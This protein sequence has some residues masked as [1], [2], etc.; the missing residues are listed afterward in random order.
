MSP[1]E[2]LVTLQLFKKALKD[3]NDDFRLSALIMI[4]E[5]THSSPWRK[6]GN[7]KSLITVC[8]HTIQCFWSFVIG[9]CLSA[10]FADLWTKPTKITNQWLWWLFWKDSPG[11]GKSW[12]WKL[13]QN[14]WRRRRKETLPEAQRTQGIEFK[15]WINFFIW[16]TFKLISVRTSSQSSKL[17]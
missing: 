5:A 7:E 2:E 6:N 1:S 15:T 8:H 9:R 4:I 13:L 3:N 12:I 17:R 16:N 10:L 14:E 11:E